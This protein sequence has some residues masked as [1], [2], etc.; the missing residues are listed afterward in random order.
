[1]ATQPYIAGMRQC[2]AHVP[3]ISDSRLLSWL[4]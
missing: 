2:A 1:M 4:I 3:H